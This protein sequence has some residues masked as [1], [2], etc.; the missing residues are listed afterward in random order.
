MTKMAALLVGLATFPLFAN[1]DTNHQ[2]QQLV[3]P[4]GDTQANEQY[5]N[6]R[7]VPLNSNKDAS[8]YVI[9]IK[10]KVKA[11]YHAEHTELVYILEG[12]AKMRL[13]EE[14]LMVTA[15]DYIRIPPKT[16]HDVSV[17]SKT[18]L[19]VLSIQTPEFKGQD[20]HFVE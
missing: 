4:L 14:V 6:I 10:E 3:H 15:G 1:E 9:F 19:K 2:S 11:H 17:T 8:D 18:P 7:V 20:R 16:I 5:D 12:T 13:G